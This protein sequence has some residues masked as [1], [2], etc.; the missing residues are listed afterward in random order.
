[1]YSRIIANFVPI[2]TTAEGEGMGYLRCGQVGFTVQ[3]AV[4][5]AIVTYVCTVC[6]SV[7]QSFLLTVWKSWTS[8]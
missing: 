2:N 1:M 6:P 4:V 3:Y 7:R 5:N 8:N